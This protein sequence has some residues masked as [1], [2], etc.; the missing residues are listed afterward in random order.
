MG[1]QAIPRLLCYANDWC[2]GGYANTGN[3][4]YRCCWILMHPGGQLRLGSESSA[5]F[6]HACCPCL[7]WLMERPP[8]LQL[9]V[10]QL[11]STRIFYALGTVYGCAHRDVPSLRGMPQK[12]CCK[13]DKTTT[14]QHRDSIGELVIPGAWQPS[15][16][17]VTFTH[18]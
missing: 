7:V 15:R 9:L 8:L 6:R 4:G 13:A 3:R 17:V 16:G 14:P 11:Y 18:A 10:V 12:K 2:H 5:A 1:C